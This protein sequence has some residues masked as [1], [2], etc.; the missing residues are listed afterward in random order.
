MK[1]KKNFSGKVSTPQESNIAPTRMQNGATAK[2][3][4]NN[5]S[6]KGG[7]NFMTKELINKCVDSIREFESLL[8]MIGQYDPCSENTFDLH[9]IQETATALQV[10]HEE[11]VKEFLGKLLP[12]TIKTEAT[13]NGYTEIPVPLFDEILKRDFSKR[14][15][16]IVLFVLRLSLGCGRDTCQLRMIDFEQAGVSKTDI[17]LE[18]TGLEQAKVI[19]WNKENSVFAINTSFNTWTIPY[20]NANREA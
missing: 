6:Q 14:Q 7:N 20:N 12:Q 1:E 3:K 16:N 10:I 4:R 8:M 18:L 2:E 11:I 5:F 15:L 17:K 19:I 9:D 13:T